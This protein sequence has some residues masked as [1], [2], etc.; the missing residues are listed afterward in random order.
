[1]DDA[2]SDDRQ[3]V[4]PLVL[5]GRDIRE[6]TVCNVAS[7]PVARIYIPEAGSLIVEFHQ[8]GKSRMPAPI[9]LQPGYAD[10]SY[11]EEGSPE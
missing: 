5:K 11:R 4:N 6:V 7:E 2:I 3:Q 1:M 8:P 9:M 10:S